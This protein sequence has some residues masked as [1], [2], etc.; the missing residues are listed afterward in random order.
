MHL[1]C[2]MLHHY[3]I[4]YTVSFHQVY[5]Y[6]TIGF[7]ALEVCFVLLNVCFAFPHVYVCLPVCVYMPYFVFAMYVCVYVYVYVC[8]TCCDVMCVYVVYVI[9]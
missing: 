3:I 5:T 8:M 9:D 7:L 1:I 6:D 4:V 2:H